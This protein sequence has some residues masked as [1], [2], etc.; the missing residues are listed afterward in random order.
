MDKDGKQTGIYAAE[1]ILKKRRR[2]V[3][4]HLVF[5]NI[6]LEILYV[7]NDLMRFAIL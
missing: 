6:W 1:K 3:G 5:Y 4:K 7:S 2:E